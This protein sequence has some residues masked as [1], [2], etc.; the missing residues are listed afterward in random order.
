MY[1]FFLNCECIFVETKRGTKPDPE[2]WQF[3]ADRVMTQAQACRGQPGLIRYF[4]IGNNGDGIEGIERDMS[5][6]LGVNPAGDPTWQYTHLSPRECNRILRER[7][8]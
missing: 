8:Q 3:A 2:V 1:A 4:L 5:A 7:Y 6:G